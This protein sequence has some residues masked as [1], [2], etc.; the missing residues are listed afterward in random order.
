MIAK[1]GKVESGE[2]ICNKC[3]IEYHEKENYN[4]SCMTHKS[5]FGGDIWWCCGKKNL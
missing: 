3:G 1:K 4:W 5:E 2:R